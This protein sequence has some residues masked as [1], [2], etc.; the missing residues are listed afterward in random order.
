LRNVS[1]WYINLFL[2]APVA[3]TCRGDC[4]L[5]QARDPIVQDRVCTHETGVTTADG[6]PMTFCHFL[7]TSRYEDAASFTRLSRI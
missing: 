3:Y 1:Y 6:T 4:T 7:V 5:A 2:P